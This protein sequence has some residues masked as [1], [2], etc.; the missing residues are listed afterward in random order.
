[1]DH[2]GVELLYKL[3][4]VCEGIRNRDG[5][6]TTREPLGVCFDGSRMSDQVEVE[7]VEFNKS[8]V[9]IIKLVRK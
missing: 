3:V 1:M 6:Y 9:K 8:K 7:E 5:S 2:P 4:P